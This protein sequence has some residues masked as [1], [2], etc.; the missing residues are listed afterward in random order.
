MGKQ[1]DIKMIFHAFFE[2][3]L[4]DFR[5]IFLGVKASLRLASLGL[6]ILQNPSDIRLENGPQKERKINLCYLCL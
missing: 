3:F 6:D 5:G 4:S 1:E 2:P